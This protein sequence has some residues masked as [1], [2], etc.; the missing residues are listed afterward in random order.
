MKI[1]I[2]DS[3]YNFPDILILGAAKC[4]TTSLAFF[5][6]QHPDV[7]MPRKEPGFFAYYDRPVEEIPSGI[8]DRQIVNRDE[9]TS[10]YAKAGDKKICDSSVAMFTN[11]RHTLE[12]IEKIYGDRKSE[13]K[14]ILI[15]RNPV[16]RAFSHYLMF[17]KNGLEELE[18]EEAIKPEIVSSRIDKQLGYDYIGGSLYA[19]RVEEILRV[20][21]QTKVYI[22]EDLKRKR[23]L[24]R[25]FL[26]YCGLRT[27]VDID[28]DT[29]LNPSGVPKNKGLIRALAHRNKA[30]DLMKKILPDRLQ[31]KLVAMK[32]KLIESSI[33]RVEID[34][35]LRAQLM[36]NTFNQDIGRLEEI[37]GR[38]LKSWKEKGLVEG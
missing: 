16:D 29:R 23:E 34:P 25:D 28:V 19:D 26:A 35:K 14:T 15:L 33:E 36:E 38:D 24:L 9:Y 18:F 3:V 13:L 5:L 7:E 21:P 22:T 1:E 31:F 2:S 10:M 11:H 8:R 6:K 32:S 12:N 4:G 17:V 30:K 27:D 37:I 20:L